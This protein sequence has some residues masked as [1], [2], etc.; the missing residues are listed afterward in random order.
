MKGFKG[1]EPGFDP[2]K[3]II[4]SIII[5]IIRKWPTVSPSCSIYFEILKNLT[6]ECLPFTTSVKCLSFQIG[7]KP[8]RQPTTPK[9]IWNVGCSGSGSFFRHTGYGHVSH[10]SGS[11]RRR[12]SKSNTGGNTREIC[13][14]PWGITLAWAWGDLQQEPAEH[15]GLL[16]A[17]VDDFTCP[18]FAWAAEPCPELPDSMHWRRGWLGQRRVVLCFCIRYWQSHQWHSL[19]QTTQR[20][21]IEY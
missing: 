5:A 16:P 18:L 12:I 2:Q 19:G 4:W 7:G 11:L 9:G 20:S 21:S 13:T 15:R 6:R 17:W 10:L 1:L 14:F 8:F 3:I